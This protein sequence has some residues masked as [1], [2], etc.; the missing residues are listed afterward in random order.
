VHRMLT[1]SKERGEKL[2]ALERERE[3]LERE[4]AI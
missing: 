3:H 2:A 1:V 4:F